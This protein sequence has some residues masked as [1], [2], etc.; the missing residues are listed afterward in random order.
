MHKLE[1]LDSGIFF[2]EI[3]VTRIFISGPADS[4]TDFYLEVNAYLMENPAEGVLW[5]STT[6][7]N[8]IVIISRNDDLG[9]NYVQ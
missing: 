7:D 6:G 5:S 1:I 3:K 8:F 9:G 4:K 2:D